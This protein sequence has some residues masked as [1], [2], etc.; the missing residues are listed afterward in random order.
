MKTINR[1]D[2]HKFIHSFILNNCSSKIKRKGGNLPHRFK[3]SFDR[4]QLI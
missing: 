3:L 1:L 2:T 4:Q